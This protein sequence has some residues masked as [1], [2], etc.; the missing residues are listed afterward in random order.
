MNLP[1]VFRVYWRKIALFTCVRINSMAAGS[2]S[3]IRGDTDARN[4]ESGLRI[5]AAGSR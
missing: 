3:L 1:G 2:F 5:G 4:V